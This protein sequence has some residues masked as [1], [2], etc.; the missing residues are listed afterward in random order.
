MLAALHVTLACNL[1]CTYCYAGSKVNK[2]MTPE[3]A[4]KSV[5]WI[6]KSGDKE[7]VVT[8]F[9]GDPLFRFDL[10][11]ECVE[12]AR[13][14]DAKF[15]W[16]MVT[17][18]TLFTDEIFDYLQANDILFTLSLDGDAIAQDLERKTVDGR[19]SFDLVL[20]NVPGML[21]VNPYTKI[22]TVVTPRTADRLAK[23]VA[24]IHGLGF[25]WFDVSPDFGGAWDRRSLATLRDSIEELA[26]YY[27]MCHRRGEKLNLNLFDDKI[28]AYALGASAEHCDACDAGKSQFSVAPSGRIYPCVQFVKDDEP[29]DEKWAIGHIDTGLNLSK[30]K[31]FLDVG[32]RPKTECTGCSFEGRCQNWCVCANWQGTGDPGAPAPFQCE[33]ERMLIPLADKVGETLWAERNPLWIDKIYN[34]TYPVLSLLQDLKKRE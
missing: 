10:V 7:N 2:S 18:G 17:N 27:L 12:H 3:I 31:A 13:T 24:Y 6:A 8:L 5:E 21:R 11:K 14:L 34:E 20:K 26:R 33:Y 30:R 9:G 16:R 4:R 15:V 22:N 32:R 25:R 28:R 29:A 19:G 23:S 1:R